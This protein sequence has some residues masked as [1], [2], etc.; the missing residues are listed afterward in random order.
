VP[1]RVVRPFTDKAI[2][3]VATDVQMGHDDGL[4]WRHRRP[5]RRVPCARYGRN[6]AR[7]MPIGG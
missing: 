1:S 5:G 3:G 6:A 7:V 4:D 2:D